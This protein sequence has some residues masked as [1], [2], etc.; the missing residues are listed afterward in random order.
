MFNF[1]KSSPKKKLEKTYEKLMKEAYRLS[2]T[3]RK[4]GD[5]K[6]AEAEEVLQKIKNLETK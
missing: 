1:M 5:A 6:M 3:D 2:H 4:A